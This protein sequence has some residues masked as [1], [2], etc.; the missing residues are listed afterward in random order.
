MSVIKLFMDVRVSKFDEANG[1]DLSEHDESAYP[2][3]IGLD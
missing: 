2:A 1:L 3:Y